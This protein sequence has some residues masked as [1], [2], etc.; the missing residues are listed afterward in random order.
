VFGPPPLDFGGPAREIAPYGPMSGPPSDL[1]LDIVGFRRK[2]SEMNY[3]KRLVS[4]VSSG[5]LLVCLISGPASA[6]KPQ[7]APPTADVSV[8]VAD[9]ADPVIA[10]DE[11]TYTA[12]IH[13]AGPSNVLA[14]LEAQ[15][16]G[17]QK[18]SVTPSQGSCTQAM[19]CDLGAISAGGEV[20]VTVVATTQSQGTASFGGYAK[21]NYTDP[22]TF[23]NYDR[24]DTAVHPAPALTG[25]CG[26]AVPNNSFATCTFKAA[27][28]PISATGAIPGFQIVC[29]VNYC[30]IIGGEFPHMTLGV[31]DST[32][33]L[34]ASCS[35][36]GGCTTTSAARVPPGTTLVC[37]ASTW[38]NSSIAI[39]GAFACTG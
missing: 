4:V 14:T 1:N 12:T 11:I 23:D 8:T 10:G 29:G 9:S 13:N 16:S 22:N 37:T 28:D 18:K 34:L 24:E 5:I 33:R 26:S 6:G 3:S 20:R 17:A 27:G 21:G 25:G 30:P 15:L 19:Y 2:G 38:S 7:K 32:G 35:G 31:S 39:L 36:S